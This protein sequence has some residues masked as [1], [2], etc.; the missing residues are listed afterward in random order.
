VVRDSV[1]HSTKMAVMACI[2]TAVISATTAFAQRSEIVIPAAK[3]ATAGQFADTPTP[4]KWWLNRNAK[5][6]G[7]RDG[8]ILMAGQPSQQEH[9]PDALWQVIP[10]FRFVPYR[11]P[12][13]VID[14]KVKGWYRIHVG[15]YGDEIEVWSTP[16]LLGKISGE[17]FPEYLQTPRGA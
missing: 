4:G 9:K 13:L 7:A 6:W 5:D 2:L 3:L 12:E 15:L 1:P 10:M 16:H 8:T 14:P 17:P 11:V